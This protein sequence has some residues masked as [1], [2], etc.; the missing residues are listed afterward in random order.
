LIG[1]RV[2]TSSP[3]FLE[4]APLLHDSPVESSLRSVS[5][6][7]NA[8]ATLERPHAAPVNNRGYNRSLVHG[9]LLLLLWRSGARQRCGTRPRCWTRPRRRIWCWS[10]S[11]CDTWCWSRACNV[12]H[13]DDT[14]PVTAYI[15]EAY[16]PDPGAD[17]GTRA[18]FM[19]GV[20]IEHP[21]PAAIVAKV[22]ATD[23]TISSC[24]P[25]D[26]RRQKK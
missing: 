12:Q 1:A 22:D 21:C 18:C 26:F 9:S 10:L 5:T 2:S 20:Q 11:R 3:I 19:T 25:A 23:T 13:V 8:R 7:A 16:A 4:Y 24:G 15:S 6:N 14:L 17:T